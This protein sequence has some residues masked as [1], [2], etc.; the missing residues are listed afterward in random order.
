MASDNFVGKRG[1][2]TGIYLW[3]NAPCQNVKYFIFIEFFKLVYF[4]EV[5]YQQKDN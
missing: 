2:Q 4:G 1:Y 3:C 5:R